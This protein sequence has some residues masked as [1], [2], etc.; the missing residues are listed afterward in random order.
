VVDLRGIIALEVYTAD[1]NF[2]NWTA[3]A[4]VEYINHIG[5]EDRTN[6]ELTFDPG[7]T[8]VP[9]WFKKSE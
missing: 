4:T 1:Q 8:G 5:G 6:I 2:M 7:Y 3:T 9:T